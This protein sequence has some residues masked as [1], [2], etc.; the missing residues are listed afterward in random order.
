MLKK[1]WVIL[2]IP[3]LEKEKKKK[4]ITP[5]NL[6]HSDKVPMSV[7]RS[8][9]LVEKSAQTLLT[10]MTPSSAQLLFSQ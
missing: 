9:N 6:R 5:Q 1:L 4:I 8:Y 10:W 2:L 7:K 3:E